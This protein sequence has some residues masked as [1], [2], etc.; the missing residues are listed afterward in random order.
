MKKLPYFLPFVSVASMALLAICLQGCKASSPTAE[1]PKAQN[2]P[3]MD[4]GMNMEKLG[5]VG[6]T[7]ISDS[8]G[9][10]IGNDSSLKFKLTEATSGATITKFEAT[11][12]K[13]LHFV[14]VDEGLVNFQH[15]H[16]SMANDGTWTQD[17]IF[18]SGGRYLL[19]ADGKIGSSGFASRQEVKV[20]GS[21]R[22]GETDF[23]PS[24]TS[25]VGAITASII[26][27]N[28]FSAGGESMVRLK[29]SRPDGWQ[30][31]L[32]APGHLILIR[33]E[34]DKFIHAHPAEDMKD[35]VV[36]FMADFK[37]P[38]IYRA[39][40]QFQR[41]GKVITFPFT[42][43]V[44]ASVTGNSKPTDMDHMGH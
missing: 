1:A 7:I 3:S 41:E 40:A 28:T 42:L 20:A 4:A 15:L 13:P 21:P 31:Y 18:P 5:S 34:G 33:K 22:G 24:K 8:S 43:N 29:L 17:V 35:G 44:S 36:E 32:Q 26:E 9:L 12:G 39:W 27:P 38:G 25:K 14:V 30:P 10:K 37:K 19:F 2:S 23:T 11:H 6:F 16:P